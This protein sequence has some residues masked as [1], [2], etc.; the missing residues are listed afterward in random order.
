MEGNTPKQLSEDLVTV[1]PKGKIVLLVCRL[2]LDLCL[3]RLFFVVGFLF[4]YRHVKYGDWQRAFNKEKIE[5][6][7]AKG[8]HHKL[9]K[10]VEG[11]MVVVTFVRNPGAEIK[12]ASIQTIKAA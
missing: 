5:I 8:S 10:E 1:L 9:L 12:A 6:R 11:R 3:C 7:V 4:F 2:M